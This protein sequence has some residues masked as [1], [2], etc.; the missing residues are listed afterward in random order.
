MIPL[1]AQASPPPDHTVSYSD[2]S[3]HTEQKSAGLEPGRSK[4]QGAFGMPYRQTF[5]G[6]NLSTYHILV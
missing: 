3:A 2:G 1:Q 5:V 6:G 4:I